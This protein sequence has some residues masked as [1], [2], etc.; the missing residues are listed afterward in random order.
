MGAVKNIGTKVVQHLD[1]LVTGNFSTFAKGNQGINGFSA[2]HQTAIS[3]TSPFEAISRYYHGGQGYGVVDSLADT[4]LIDKGTQGARNWALKN[5]QTKKIAGAYA[6][7][8]LTASV[9]GGLTHD[10]AGN[11]DIAG[12]PGI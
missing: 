7:A 5:I 10:S 6:G 4:F 11:P 2:L 3:L 12:L 8:S 9:V 1:D